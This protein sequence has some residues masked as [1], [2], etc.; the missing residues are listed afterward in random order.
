MSGLDMAALATAYLVFINFT[1]FIIFLDDKVRAQKRV[2]RVSEQT[3]LSLA[4]IGGS[5]AA[6]FAR[7]TLRHKT[8]KQPFSTYLWMISGVQIGAAI[9]LFLI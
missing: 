2:Y 3:L 8:H 6:F 1:T 5:P 9:A 7:H 4:L